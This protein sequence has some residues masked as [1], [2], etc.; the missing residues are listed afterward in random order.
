[1][2]PFYPA[3]S[4]VSSPA[5]RSQVA[6]TGFENIV[7]HLLM[8]ASNLSFSR[9]YVTSPTTETGSNMVEYI[10]LLQWKLCMTRARRL[11]AACPI[12]SA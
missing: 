7:A 5:F 2:D 11:L 12:Y 1:M 6:Y 4:L 9:W 3:Q 8:A 10:I